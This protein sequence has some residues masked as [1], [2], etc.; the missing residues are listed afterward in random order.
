M[1][2]PSTASPPTA[3]DE[4]CALL[5]D[6]RDTEMKQYIQVAADTIETSN[7]PLRSADTTETSNLPSRSAAFNGRVVHL[8]DQ[9]RIDVKESHPLLRNS[10]ADKI[11][12]FI[13]V[14][15]TA[16]KKLGSYGTY[17][18]HDLGLSQEALKSWPAPLNDQLQFT[19]VADQDQFHKELDN[20]I[21]DKV[22]VTTQDEHGFHVGVCA[23]LDKLHNVLSEK[24][25]YKT[26]R[27]ANFFVE[28]FG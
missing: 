8:V 17:L 10:S 16:D 12:V 28:A 25:Q 21:K 15:G 26:V 13:K 24:F 6:T 11:S 14:S 5:K 3:A 2:A 27:S 1:A 7:L 4:I 23:S 19:V 18:T 22:N 9:L 20:A